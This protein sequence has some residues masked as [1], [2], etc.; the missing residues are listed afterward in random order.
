[1][2]PMPTH[3]AGTRTA[4]LPISVVARQTGLTPTTLRVW[5]RR[6]GLGASESSRGGHRRYS[7][8]DVARLQ[9][10]RQLIRQGV[11]TAEAARIVLA[12]TDHGLALPA[13]AD[14]AAH[15]LAA[16][17]LE[18]DGPGCRRLL[19]DHLAAHGVDETWQLVLRPVLAALGTQ[20]PELPHG[21]AVEHLLSHVAA[22]VL[23]EATD[24]P[25]TPSTPPTGLPSVLLACG[26][27]EEH[28]LPLVAL[29]AALSRSGVGAALLG[30]GTPVDTLTRAV[31]RRR[32]AVVMVLALLPELADPTVFDGLPDTAVRIAAGP[33]WDGTPLPA[34]V[35]RV[36]GLSGALES[37]TDAVATAASQR[38]PS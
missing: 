18:L 20:W 35:R 15:H 11:P 1:M 10:A 22:A 32:P 21:I 19:R 16:A 29:A 28:D 6:Y 9:A 4:A 2:T 8:G 12:A 30:A 17:A 24:G 33:G 5:Q 3:T 25:G 38:V 31:H 27:H 23:A 13:P 7:P 14:P 26:P 34:A 37:I 36:D